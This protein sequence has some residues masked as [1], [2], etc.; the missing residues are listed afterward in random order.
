MRL[1]RRA[2]YFRDW[3]EVL[4]A[5][6]DGTFARD[7]SPDPVCRLQSALCGWRTPFFHWP[8]HWRHQR[9]RLPAAPGS[10]KTTAS[11][12]ADSAGKMLYADYVGVRQLPHH[13]WPDEFGGVS[14]PRSLVAICLK[15]PRSNGVPLPSFDKKR[16]RKLP[17]KT[18]TAWDEG[19]SPD[20]FGTIDM[21]DEG[22]PA[23][24][25]PVD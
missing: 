8:A 17:M 5:S 12:V 9:P 24:R 20:A 19:L 11:N 23:Q 4:V 15:L 3:Q 6:S 21:D 1:V 16:V 2:A 10:T 22:M 14:L 13:L 7:I 25:T 18:S